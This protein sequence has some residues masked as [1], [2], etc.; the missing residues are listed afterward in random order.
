M[1]LSLKTMEV[2]IKGDQ[3][4]KR[5]RTVQVYWKV[6]RVK[7][8]FHLTQV[9][10]V[11][12]D[13]AVNSLELVIPCENSLIEHAF[14][15]ENFQR[16]NWTTF[17]KF[18]L[19]P[20]SFQWNENV[21]AINTPTGISVLTNLVLIVVLVLESKGLTVSTACYWF[22]SGG[23]VVYWARLLVTPWLLVISTLRSDIASLKC[24]L[25]LFYF[26]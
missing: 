25:L 10:Y 14:S 9:P 1:P 15:P 24:S 18:H 26:Y 8:V 20:R 6:R 7:N 19:C 2:Q 21:C 23:G 12:T 5:F 22:S 3:W 4:N 16:E 13:I 17:S 11:G